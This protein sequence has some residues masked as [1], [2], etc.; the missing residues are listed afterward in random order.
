MAGRGE[1]GVAD[2][3]WILSKD[4]THN[5]A[6]MRLAMCYLNCEKLDEAT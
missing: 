4:P 1:A 6:S 2:A 3:E 5:K